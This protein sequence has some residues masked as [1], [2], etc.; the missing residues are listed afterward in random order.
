MC[1]VIDEDALIE[2]FA[3]S[4]Q[5]MHLARTPIMDKNKH[6]LN[7]H[8]QLYAF[9]FNAGGRPDGLWFSYGS[10][11]LQTAKQ[12]NNP[13]FPVCCYLYKLDLTNSTKLL[14]ITDYNEFKKFDEEIPDYWVNLDYFEVDFIDY[15]ND[16][17]VKSMKK[18]KLVLNQLRKK[19][20]EC[21]KD[22]LLNNHIIFTDTESA[23]RNCKFY[24]ET[25]IPIERF[26]Y[27]DWAT[28]AEKYSGIVFDFWDLNDAQTMKYMWFQSLDVVSGCIWDTTI[29]KDL[30]L[31]YH[32]VD[33][34]TWELS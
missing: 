7:N 10:K 9:G 17:E 28:V 34:S 13:K 15:L 2:K 6:L 25:D 32:K 23:I 8:P 18:H 33:A 24:K 29:I 27:K 22:T 31:C 26:K 20:N 12:L 14:T 21:L 19:P 1:D 4:K 3:D 11:W 5:L 30:E 16:Q